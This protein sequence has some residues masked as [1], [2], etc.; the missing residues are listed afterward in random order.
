MDSLIVLAAIFGQGQRAHTYHTNDYQR[1]N[2]QREGFG[3]AR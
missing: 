3:F 2:S 1:Q